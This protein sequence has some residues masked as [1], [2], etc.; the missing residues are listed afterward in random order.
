LKYQSQKRASRMAQG[1]EHLPSKHKAYSSN[2]S[3]IKQ[4][5]MIIFLSKGE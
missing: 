2:P 5:Q 3:T 1:V 4:K